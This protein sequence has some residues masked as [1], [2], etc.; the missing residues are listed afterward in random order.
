M[1]GEEEEDVINALKTIQIH[2]LVQQ[3]AAQ[4]YERRIKKDRQVK[5]EEKRDWIMSSIEHTHCLR[6]SSTWGNSFRIGVDRSSFE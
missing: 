1:A 6:R 3:C 4:Q 5:A 2:A